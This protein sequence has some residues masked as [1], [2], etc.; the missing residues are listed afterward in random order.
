MESNA[1]NAL[2]QFL[3]IAIVPVAPFGVP[4]NDLCLLPHPKHSE[5][6]IPTGLKPS[7][8]RCGDDLPRGG[9]A[10]LGTEP[11]ISVNPESG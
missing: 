2:P 10:T 4:P 6:S 1:G 3:G 8:Q 7:A 5:K 9:V 11:E